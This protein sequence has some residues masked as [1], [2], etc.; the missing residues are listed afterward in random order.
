MI[1]TNLNKQ[2][3]GL[4]FITSLGI[5]LLVWESLIIQNSLTIIEKKLEKFSKKIEKINYFRK[6][7]KW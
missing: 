6:I 7:F 2:G 4:L 3:L 1:K 5:I